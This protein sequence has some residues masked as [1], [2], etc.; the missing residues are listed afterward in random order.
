MDL[1]L[2]SSVLGDDS[3]NISLKSLLFDAE[4]SQGILSQADTR[5]SIDPYSTQAILFHRG[6]PKG[7]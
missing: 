4:L 5:T 3:T 6:L 7:F 2:L 1:G